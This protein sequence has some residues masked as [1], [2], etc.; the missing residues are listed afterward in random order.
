MADV[1][2]L[3]CLYLS[4]I[5]TARGRDASAIVHNPVLNRMLRLYGR[6]GSWLITFYEDAAD[7]CSKRP[8][9]PTLFVDSLQ[10]LAVLRTLGR[11]PTAVYLLGPD[12][13]D[14]AEEAE[15]YGVTP[16]LTCPDHWFSLAEH[17]S[18]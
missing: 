11:L 15:D 13:E 6:E 18:P 9:A 3:H 2:P 1:N 17:R 7:L 16:L 14:L 10:D 8:A 12:D 5:P 4:L